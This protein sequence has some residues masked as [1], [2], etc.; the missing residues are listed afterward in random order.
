MDCFP[1]YSVL[2]LKIMRKK[3]LSTFIQSVFMPVLVGYS[4]LSACLDCNRGRRYCYLRLSKQVLN[5]CV[6]FST[7]AG[8]IWLVKGFL[9]SSWLFDFFS[10][11]TMAESHEGLILGVLLYLILLLWPFQVKSFPIPDLR[12]AP[13]TTQKRWGV[14]FTRTDKKKNVNHLMKLVMIGFKFSF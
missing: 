14:L 13:T 8:V 7:N 1:L 9:Y 11:S 4:P 3:T 2:T 5:R 6:C 12:Q 10:V